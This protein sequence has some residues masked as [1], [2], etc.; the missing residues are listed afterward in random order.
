MRVIELT[1]FFIKT[2]KEYKGNLTIKDTIYYPVAYIKF[3]Y[4]SLG[5]I[6]EFYI[7][8]NNELECHQ[9]MLKDWIQVRNEMKIQL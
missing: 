9:L 6:E 7:R 8:E 1:K 2:T 3:M 5:T 4:N